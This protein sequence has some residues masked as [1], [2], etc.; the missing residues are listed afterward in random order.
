M[1]DLLPDAVLHFT[2]PD[3]NHGLLHTLSWPSCTTSHQ[4]Q[5]AWTPLPEEIFISILLWLP[6]DSLVRCMRVCRE[7]NQFIQYTRAL[8]ED[9]S[10]DDD[11]NID[12]KAI[13]RYMQRAG[14]NGIR[15]VALGSTTAMKL[16]VILFIKALLAQGVGNLQYLGMVFLS[17][18]CAIMSVSQY[19]H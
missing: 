12:Q 6:L 18:S 14:P 15:R 17:H 19:A 16:D 11:Y 4:P 13:E 9:I 5:P 1:D 3:F 8:W 7:W 10:C 2:D